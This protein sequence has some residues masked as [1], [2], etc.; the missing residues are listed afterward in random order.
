MKAQLLKQKAEGTEVQRPNL[1]GIP[2][3]MKLDFERRSGLS[4]DD[5]QEHYNSDKPAR[6]GALAYTQGSQVY[7]GRGQERYLPHELGHVIQQKQ[8]LVHPTGVENGYPVNLSP[9][10]EHS[11]QTFQP[12]PNTGITEAKP[13]TAI[14]FYRTPGKPEQTE[15]T[16]GAKNQ[17]FS[18]QAMDLTGEDRLN[19]QARFQNGK[20]YF[21]NQASPVNMSVIYVLSMDNILYIHHEPVLTGRGSFTQSNFLGSA[22]VK[23]AGEMYI[24]DGIIQDINNGSGHF[25]PGA[26]ALEY[27][28]D[29]LKSQGA[30]MSKLIL[31]T[32]VENPDTKEI[33]K[34][35]YTL[36][37][38]RF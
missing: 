34:I 24:E 13:Q 1:P 20:I 18:D 26:P 22:P 25:R 15:L 3:Q 35:H 10:L 16:Q 36:Q 32:I 8:G 37:W 23:A 21:P 33:E 4:F 27:M 11:V 7:M 14:Q 5:V 31:T 12:A 30:D 28:L 29:Y 2:T 6:L 19:Y 38:K 17:R 9:A